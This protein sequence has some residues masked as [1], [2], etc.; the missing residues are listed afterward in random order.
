MLVKTLLLTVRDF[1]KD[2]ISEGTLEGVD[3]RTVYTLPEGRIP[4]SMGQR[5][6]CIH[7]QGVVD[8]SVPKGDVRRRRVR[9]GVSLIQRIRNIPNDRFDSTAYLETHSMSDVLEVVGDF[10]E[11]PSLLALFKADIIAANDTRLGVT[12]TFLMV[13][14]QLDPVHLYPGFFGGDSE[15]DHSQ[16]IAGY[17]MT[18]YFLSPVV[19]KSISGCQ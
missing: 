12:D 10:V 2:K 1:L 6:I 9:F 13:D 14:G 16:K 11:S 7:P 17:K 15:E 4:P 19:H 8:V 5:G 18:Y 3:S